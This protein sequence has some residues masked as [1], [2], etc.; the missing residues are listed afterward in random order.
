MSKF[1]ITVLFF[2]LM[3]SCNSR[4]FDKRK[5]KF[6][7]EIANSIEQEYPQVYIVVPVDDDSNTS[8]EMVLTSNQLYY[9]YKE[10]DTNVSRK[11]FAQELNRILTKNQTIKVV[12]EI[13]N[14]KLKN[15]KISKENCVSNLKLDELICK[16]FE[17][18][19][20]FKKS[21]DSETFKCVVYSIF[22][23][24]LF[25]TQDDFSGYY[26]IENSRKVKKML[27][28]CECTAN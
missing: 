14:I 18:N 17:P 4:I 10:V 15:C 28:K 1:L 2:F 11:T 22:K 3:C 6:S 16:Y 8:Q 13:S 26:Y 20:Y 9:Y 23:R 27:S 21:I 19:G 12:P 7:R 24:K 25:I 5:T